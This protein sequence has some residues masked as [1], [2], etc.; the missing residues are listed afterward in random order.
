[1]KCWNCGLDT[2]KPCDELGK[3]WFKCSDCGATWVK[4][5][6]LVEGALGGTWKDKDGFSHWHSVPLRKRKK[7]K[8]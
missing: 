1:M 5:P 7:A 8:K 2:M 6:E 4:M 3:G